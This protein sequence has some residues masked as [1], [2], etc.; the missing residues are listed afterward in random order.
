[1]IPRVGRQQI[2]YSLLNNPDL[3]LLVRLVTPLPAE[4]EAHFA[5]GAWSECDF[6]GYAPIVP[7]FS[8]I[9]VDGD[10]RGVAMSELMTWTAGAGI[11]P[12]T[13]YAIALVITGE[14]FDECPIWVK[15]LDPT[16]TLGMPG[17]TFSR[18]IYL[19]DDNTLF[20]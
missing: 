4:D 15:Y 6:D 17:E 12:Q 8:T 20:L 18:R 7:V 11:T 9:G 2:F 13:I 10:D 19:R 14:G 1:M 5:E 3:A 16:V